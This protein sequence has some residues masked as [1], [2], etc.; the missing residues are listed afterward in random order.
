MLSI[1]SFVLSFHSLFIFLIIFLSNTHRT[2]S[3]SL[4]NV[5]T[6]D[7]YVT[8]G[9]IKVLYMLILGLGG[10]VDPKVGVGWVVKRI[11][12]VSDRTLKR[13]LSLSQSLY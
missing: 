5:H 2:C 11:M 13:R 12:P 8:T 10:C 9:L 3:F 4:S 7:P 6:S 1:P